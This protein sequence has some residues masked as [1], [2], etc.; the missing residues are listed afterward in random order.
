LIKLKSENSL[1]KERLEEVLT[2]EKI[3]KEENVK[4]QS[5][6]TKMKIELTALRSEYENE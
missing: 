5:L 1:L 3:L 4:L 6:N 2:A